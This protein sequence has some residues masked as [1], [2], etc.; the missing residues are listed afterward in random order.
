MTMK[1]FLAIF[2]SLVSLWGC[3]HNEMNEVL[4]N[5]DEISI[6][7]KGAPQVTY[8]EDTCQLAYNDSN[9]EYRVYNDRLAFWF[10]IRCNEK[11]VTTGQEVRAYVSWTGE[12][13]TKAYNNLLFRVEKTD[14]NGKVWLWNADNRIGI[15]IKD[16]I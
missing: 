4:L 14:E 7:W 3:N 6:T 1:R 15:I 9:L 11:P 8:N 16:I 10:V 13:S 5:R 12:R 2:L